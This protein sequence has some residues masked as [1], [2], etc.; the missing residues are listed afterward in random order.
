MLDETAL[1]FSVSRHGHMVDD[2]SISDLQ[3]L[4]NNKPPEH[5]LEF[6]PQ[7][8]LP[9]RLGLLVDTSESV[10]NRA[11]FEKQAAR[12][13]LQRMITV[14]SDLA[15]VAGFNSSISVAQDFTAD[16][17]ALTVGVD[18]LARR[19]NSTS[20]FDAIEYGCWKLAAYPDE[21]RVAKVLIVL[22][23]GEDNSS[24]RS[25]RQSIKFAEDAGVTVYTV[26]T[27][28]DLDTETD[29][30]RVLKAIAEGTGG[31][32]IFPE[33]LRDL[34]R[35]LSKLSDVIRSRYLIAY[36]PADFVPDG[37]YRTVQISAAKDGKRMQVRA[38]GGYYARFADK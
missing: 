4:D 34:D 15:F 2:L 23:D 30:A 8:Q 38:H 29:A 12:K 6:V 21:D 35:Y 31:K 17:I 14:Q 13:F 7:S 11:P 3:I 5:I 37:K 26:S 22:T 18:K 9:L 28:V 10:E 20:I 19:G 33:T 27:G 32:A 1:F 24:H 25:L 16:P 36:K